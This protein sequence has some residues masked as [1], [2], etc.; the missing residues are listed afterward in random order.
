MQS[1]M[2]DNNPTLTGVFQLLVFAQF[3]IIITGQQAT[4]GTVEMKLSL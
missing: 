1:S 3:H 4:N 2:L